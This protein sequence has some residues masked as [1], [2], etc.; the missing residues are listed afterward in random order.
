MNEILVI[1][2]IFVMLSI[3]ALL[4]YFVKVIIGKME[5]YFLSTEETLIFIGVALIAAGWILGV[6][7]L[8]GAGI[9]IGFIVIFVALISMF[10]REAAVVSY[11]VGVWVEGT[12]E[13][14]RAQL[15][16]SRG[17]RK[18]ERG[19]EQ[20]QIASELTIRIAAESEPPTELD[21]LQSDIKRL[22]AKLE[23]LGE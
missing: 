16:E 19:I 20:E 14:Y 6:G 21:E 22:I 23:S 7:T 18:S 8:F 11:P 13:I 1:A 4:L 5:K 10:K 17:E 12:G 2:L 9:A 15:S 3:G